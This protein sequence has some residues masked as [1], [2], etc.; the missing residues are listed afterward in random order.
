MRPILQNSL[1]NLEI[2]FRMTVKNSKKYIEYLKYYHPS[3]LLL[4]VFFYITLNLSLFFPHF[5]LFEKY[6]RI[7]CPLCGT[8]QSIK[9]FIN[10]EFTKS[11]MLSFVGIPFIVYLILYQIF[12]I[13]KKH[14]LIFHM[15]KFLT[16]LLF[17]N[18]I[19]QFLWQ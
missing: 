1:M 17:I 15:E 14:I 6:L 3:I 10:G 19:K 13:F 18:F 7:H 8:T 12:L 11:I 4:F 9:Y 16:F 2:K 5:C